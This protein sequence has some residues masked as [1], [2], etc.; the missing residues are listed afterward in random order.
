MAGE[1]QQQHIAA[2]RIQDWF[3]SRQ[4]PEP[5]EPPQDLWIELDHQNKAACEIQAFLRT[6]TRRQHARVQ[7]V[8]AASCRGPLTR[9]PDVPSESWPRLLSKSAKLSTMWVQST[10][11]AQLEAELIRHGTESLPPTELALLLHCDDGELLCGQLA[12]L[13]R[14]LPV[15]ELALVTNLVASLLTM[16]RITH[17]LLRW[18]NELLG[19]PEL[20]TEDQ[21]QLRCLTYEHQSWVLYCEG[22]F[23]RA[24][25]LSLKRLRYELGIDAEPLNQNCLG[26]ASCHLHIAAIQEKLGDRSGALMH[27]E[28]ALRLAQQ[29]PDGGLVEGI[30]R[31]SLA[32]QKVKQGDI[33]GIPAHYWVL[34]LTIG[35][36]SLCIR[37]CPR[38]DSCTVAGD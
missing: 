24:L 35:C 33:H 1:Q 9:Y 8:V 10:R 7:R 5:D 6:H 22:E 20:S 31:H 32:V 15:N 23:A 26:V 17:S 12:A 34:P 30:A 13:E 25:E 38:S 36:S 21:L 14:R 19:S 2:A 18:A 29:A 27:T 28:S 3:R 4:P 37:W 11:G 16:P